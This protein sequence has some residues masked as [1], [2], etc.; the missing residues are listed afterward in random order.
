MG[1]VVK[2]FSS[3]AA[4]LLLAVPQAQAQDN[5]AVP[6]S[7][8]GGSVTRQQGCAL[9]FGACAGERTTLAVRLGDAVARRELV[10]AQTEFDE[11]THGGI[12]R[13][14]PVT[15]RGRTYGAIDWSLGGL[16]HLQGKAFSLTKSFPV[17]T[18]GVVTLGAYA[19]DVTGTVAA[20]AEVGASV[21]ALG[22][23]Y[24]VGASYSRQKST[25]FGGLTEALLLA[26]PVS[27][28]HGGAF[29]L[30]QQMNAGIDRAHGGIGVGYV[31]GQNS[32]DRSLL[33]QTSE[34]LALAGTPRGPVVTIHAAMNRVFLDPIG[35]K[36]NQKL[37]AYADSINQRARA[38]AEPVGVALPQVT[39]QQ[40]AGL[41]GRETEPKTTVALQLGVTQPIGSQSSATL[42]ASRSSSGRTKRGLV[43][44]FQF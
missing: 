12:G 21:A 44:N 27:P 3:A 24:R 17:G 25:Q 42:Q 28:T 26:L 4:A 41:V 19:G 6:T 16:Q 30:T 2:H 29:V 10:V 39:A 32:A 23:R 14:Y 20:A 37:A 18:D 31:Y 34:G 43:F 7:F 40:L 11:Q 13:T 9:L 5:G 33:R 15:F 38:A 1:D 22:Q 35:E 8:I 36:G